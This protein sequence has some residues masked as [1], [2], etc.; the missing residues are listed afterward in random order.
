MILLDFAPMYYCAQQLQ[1]ILLCKRGW[2][3]VTH[4][5]STL[6][7][8]N[9]LC[10]VPADDTAGRCENAE[11]ARKAVSFADRGVGPMS[12]CSANHI[13]RVRERWQFY[14]SELTKAEV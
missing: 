3:S 14:H 5:I 1:L 6:H 7:P 12:G 11:T 2:R 10:T 9:T 4:R 8:Y 13:Q